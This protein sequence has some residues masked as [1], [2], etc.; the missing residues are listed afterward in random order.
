MQAA[1]WKEEVEQEFQPALCPDAKTKKRQPSDTDTLCSWTNL[2]QSLSGPL[3][4]WMLLWLRGPVYPERPTQL[5]NR[6][7]LRTLKPFAK[8]IVFLIQQ[9]LTPPIIYKSPF[10]FL[11]I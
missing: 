8:I 6:I 5:W 11:E 7:K 10:V 4:N 1:V 2:S 9:H 3:L